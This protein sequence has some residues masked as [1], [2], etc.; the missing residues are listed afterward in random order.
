MGAAATAPCITVLPVTSG[1]FAAV[2]GCRRHTLEA[3]SACHS[4]S[5][6]FSAKCIYAHHALKP[7][8]I[9][10]E[11]QTDPR[12]SHAFAA[13]VLLSERASRTPVAGA[14]FL[15]RLCVSHWFFFRDALL[16]VLQLCLFFSAS[17]GSHECVPWSPESRSLP[18]P[19]RGAALCVNL[20]PKPEKPWFFGA[21]ETALPDPLENRRIE[22]MPL[23]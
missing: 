9:C 6:A 17:H 15:C 12:L 14:R 16:L 19:S 4:N 5:L 3:R 18:R 13:P 7:S 22:E 8:E 21:S 11:N 23:F 10:R 1:L 20:A 2:S